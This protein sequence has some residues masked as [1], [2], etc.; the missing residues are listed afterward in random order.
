MIIAE[1]FTYQCSSK[2]KPSM[3]VVEVSF[4]CMVAVVGK[5]VVLDQKCQIPQLALEQFW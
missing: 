5:L 3:L 2:I 4:G 1:P